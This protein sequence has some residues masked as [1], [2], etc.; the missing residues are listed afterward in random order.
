MPQ[1]SG[2]SGQRRAHSYTTLHRNVSN[3]L[4]V[5]VAQHPRRIAPSRPFVFRIQG[6]VLCTPTIFNCSTNKFRN[7]RRMCVS[8]CASRLITYK[9]VE[10]K[11]KDVPTYRGGL[12]LLYKVCSKYFSFQCSHTDFHVN[13]A[14]TACDFKQF[15]KTNIFR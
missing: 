6:W 13:F 4:P 8:L 1:S 7:V 9:I 15:Q 14:L 10:L 11:G 2:F 3:Y 12:I 5:D